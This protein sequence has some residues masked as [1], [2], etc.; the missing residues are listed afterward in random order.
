MDR[1]DAVRDM[2]SDECE[3][4]SMSCLQLLHVLS[5]SDQC[6]KR[7]RGCNAMKSL[8]KNISPLHRYAAVTMETI[9]KVIL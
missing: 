7:L 9:K 1:A 4:V 5:E 6:V 2:N 8:L 3:A